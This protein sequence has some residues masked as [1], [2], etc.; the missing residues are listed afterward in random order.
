[1][2]KIDVIKTGPESLVP[3]HIALPLLAAKDFVS[4]LPVLAYIILK[5]EKNQ[6]VDDKRQRSEILPVFKYL[7]EAENCM[8]ILVN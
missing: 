8:P 1:M 4:R 5:S 7:R 2:A 3:T 6:M